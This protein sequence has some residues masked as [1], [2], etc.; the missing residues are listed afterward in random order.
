MSAFLPQHDPHERRRQKDLASRQAEYHYNYDYVSPLALVDHVP[1][2][3]EFSISFMI[4]LGERVLTVLRN[5]A[6]VAKIPEL[7]A[8]HQ[9][10]HRVFQGLVKAVTFDAE[11]LNEVIK[12]AIEMTGA[13]TRPE[14]YDE[15]ARMFSKIGLPPIHRD[16]RRD[17]VF[18]DMRVAGPNPVMIKQVSELDDRFP[19]TDADFQVALP[20]D[21]LEAAGQEGRL[22]L[23]DFQVLEQL[24]KS[25]FPAEKHLHSPLALFA[26]DKAS[27]RLVPVAIQCQQKPAPDNPIFTKNDGW[28]WLIAKTVVSMAD[29]NVHEPVTHL[30]RTHLFIEPFVIATQRQLATRHPLGLLLR[31]HFEGT[32]QINHMAHT[33]LIAPEGGVDRFCNGSIGSIGKLAVYGHQAFHF[34]DVMLPSTF[35]A[36][37]VDDPSVLPNYPYRDDAMLYWDAIRNWVTAYLSIYYTCNDDIQQDVEL[38]NWFQELIAQDGGRVKYFGENGSIATVQYLCDAVTL[39][40]Y[41]TSVQHAAVNFPQFDLMSYSPAMPLACFSPAPTSKTGATEQ[42]YLDMLPPLEVAN[43]Q[44]SMG[45]AI[46]TLR[47]TQ[48]GRYGHGHF[49]DHRVSGPLKEFQQRLSDIGDTIAARNEERRPYTILQPGG[50]PQSINV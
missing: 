47:Y 25:Y 37:G 9:R 19:V 46:G 4:Q 1:F 28:N 13:C 36:R 43:L 6:D 16:Y 29:G 32:L 34:N 48:L 39:I 12:N 17:E 18:A 22:F 23:T 10:E 40:L 38:T 3:D 7:R 50:I 26:L 30:A 44:M 5:L 35:K 24:E 31:P 2:R 15:Y 49:R 42:D 20:G 8:A 21:T 33:E 11:G 27:R 41:T 45:H 14:S